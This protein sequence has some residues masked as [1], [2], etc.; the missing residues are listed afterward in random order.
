MQPN[1]DKIYAKLEEDQQN[2]QSKL[3]KQTV[4][5]EAQAIKLKQLLTNFSTELDKDF[6]PD[7]EFE[8][9]LSFLANFVTPIDLSDEKVLCWPKEE[10]LQRLKWS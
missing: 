7:K 10:Y 5:V 6:I 1:I 4:S 2:L 9:K 8:I 3:N